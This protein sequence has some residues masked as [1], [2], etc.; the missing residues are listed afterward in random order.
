MVIDGGNNDDE[1]RMVS[2]IKALGIEEID[3]LIGTHPD[4]DHVGGL[5]AIIDVFNIGNFYMPSIAVTTKTFQSVLASAKA[6]NLTVQSAQK[7]IDL[8]FDSNCRTDVLS[9]TKKS[10]DSNEMSVVV[11]LACGKSS[12]LFSGDIEGEAE[13]ILVD[14]SSDLDVDVLLVPHHGSNGST[15][16]ELLEATTPKISL[17]Q[18]GKDN[19]YGHPG[20]ETLQRLK[21]S[22]TEIYRTDEMGNI[23]V[24]G[25]PQT[26][27][28]T[29]NK[30]SIDA[31]N[32][33]QPSVNSSEEMISQLNVFAKVKEKSP[34]QNTIEEVQITVVDQEQKPVKDVEIT[35][36][37]Q[38]ASKETVYTAQ[39]NA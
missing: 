16:T 23:V 36:T 18:A 21:S 39:T 19:S 34:K 15:T 20:K 37:L 9:P 1:A 25:N 31:L 32:E 24:I 29:V 5:D 7:G 2:Y 13:E 30:K 17:I 33:F 4:A 8:Q 27:E 6:K 11:K 26:G 22:G 35:L 12:F 10:K 14:A 28:Y 38:F 3:I